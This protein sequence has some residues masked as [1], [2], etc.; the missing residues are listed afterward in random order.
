MKNLKINKKKVASLMLAFGILLYHSK[1]FSLSKQIEVTGNKVNVR[2]TPT[3]STKNN[4]IGRVNTGDT[5]TVID[6][7]DGWYLIDY[8]GE[9]A[10]IYD[11]YGKEVFKEDNYTECDNNDCLTINMAKITGNNINIR[12]SN[13]TKSKIIGFADV[14]DLFTIIDK[15]GDWYVIDYLGQ[16]GYIHSKYVKECSV[17]KEDMIIQ[18]M[19]YLPNE[20]VFYRDINNSY[21][22]TLPKNQF[23]AVIKEEN[24]YYKV[25]IDGII[26]YVKKDDTKKLTNTFIVSDLGRQIVRVYKNNKEVFRAHIISGRKSMQTDLGK[27]KIGHHIKD[28]QLTP[29]YRVDFWMQYNGD[30]G[31][32]DA[33]WQ[34]IKNF[35][36]V[37]DDAYERFSMGQSRTYP[38]KYGSHGC[39]N[40]THDDAEII[41]NIID[42]GDDVLII[43]SN[44]LAYSVLIC[45]QQKVKKLV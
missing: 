43:E 30:E 3:T 14:T 36:E 27:F 29:D 44:D 23:A 25:R 11:Q 20:S 15:I 10:Y 21:I 13:S 7:K 1:S 31:F 35:F 2:L 12:S 39:D 18:K 42:V 19:V 45:K 4:I 8:Y 22:T 6:H 16:T 26:G 40:L 24:S 5:F 37:A 38:F 41:F 32:H 28:Y 9:Y 33:Y 17:A 34:A